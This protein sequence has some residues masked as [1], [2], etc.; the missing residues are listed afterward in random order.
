MDGVEEIHSDRERHLDDDKK[1]SLCGRK[2]EN[3][4]FRNQAKFLAL[5]SKTRTIA[6]PALYWGSRVTTGGDF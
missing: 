2:R 5:T 4:A 3:H 1:V 6:S